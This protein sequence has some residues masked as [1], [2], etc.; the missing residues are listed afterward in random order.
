MPAARFA[1]L[2]RLCDQAQ[3]QS[4]HRAALNR[5]SWIDARLSM[6]LLHRFTLRLCSRALI[7]APE[8]PGTAFHT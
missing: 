3:Q 1:D 4:R 6:R 8:F 2:V 7:A 5:F